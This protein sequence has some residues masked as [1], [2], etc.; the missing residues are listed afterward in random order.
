V[1]YAPNPGDNNAPH[2]LIVKVNPNCAQEDPNQ[3][4]DP[5]CA[6]ASPFTEWQFSVSCP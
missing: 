6:A 3:T 2:F 4:I 1:T 5:S